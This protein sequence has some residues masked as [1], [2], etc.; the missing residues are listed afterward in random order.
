MS[1]SIGIIKKEQKCHT[2][3]CILRYS[4]SWLQVQ[5]HCCSFSKSREKELLWQR[6]MSLC[7][8]LQRVEA[9]F[10]L[11]FRDRSQVLSPTCQSATLYMIEWYKSI[12]LTT[13]GKGTNDP[14]EKS[15]SAWASAREDCYADFRMPV[16]KSVWA[17]GYHYK[18][19]DFLLL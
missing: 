10:Q 12:R 7:A 17:K 18:S 6:A 11:F 16:S 19:S 2:D 8:M 13:T 4:K 15:P 14:L 5:V 3:G 1:I 9:F